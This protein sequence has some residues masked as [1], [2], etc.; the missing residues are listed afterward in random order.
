MAMRLGTAPAVP[1]G[2]GGSCCEVPFS[3]G[4]GKSL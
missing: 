3:R 1:G 4:S 2:R